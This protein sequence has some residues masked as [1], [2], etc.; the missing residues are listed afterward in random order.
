MTEE[1]AAAFLE[2]NGALPVTNGSFD[3]LN[4]PI[5]TQEAYKVVAA[6]VELRSSGGKV[7]A[8]TGNKKVSG[9]WFSQPA[10]AAE[11]SAVVSKP[12]SYLDA[13][14]LVLQASSS[15]R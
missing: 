8:Q 7:N 9:H 2:R 12:L 4:Q 5:A 6:L 15:I 3:N 11:K 13:A 1:T 10:F 14:Q